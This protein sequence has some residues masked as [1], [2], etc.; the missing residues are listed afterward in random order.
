MH[1][2][3]KMLYIKGLTTT[4]ETFLTLFPQNIPEG[5]ESLTALAVRGGGGA[6][7]DLRFSYDSNT[8]VV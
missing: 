4:S 3:F 1:A 6:V 7:S 2:Q 8:V 5:G